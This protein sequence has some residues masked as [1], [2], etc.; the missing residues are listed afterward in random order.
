MMTD[1]ETETDKIV[2]DIL[3]NDSDDDMDITSTGVQQQ[4]QQEGG[5][6]DGEDFNASLHDAMK[7]AASFLDSDDDVDPPV[8]AAAAVASTSMNQHEADEIEEENPFGLYDYEHHTGTIMDTVATTSGDDN[9]NDD[10][11]LAVHQS[12]STL[13]A[14]QLCVHPKHAHSFAKASIFVT[15]PVVALR[16]QTCAGCQQY[17]KQGGIFSSSSNNNNR[18]ACITD[19]SVVKCMAC[20]ALAHRTCAFQS[21]LEWKEICPVNGPSIQKAV[22]GIATDQAEDE[23]V[24]TSRVEDGDEYEEAL[25][26]GSDR[27][28]RKNSSFLSHCSDQS[29]ES[30]ELEED[31]EDSATGVIASKESLNLD[32]ADPVV[33]AA[34]S[35]AQDERVKAEA[36]LASSPGGVREGKSPGA[37]RRVVTNLLFS[38]KNKKKQDIDIKKVLHNTIDEGDSDQIPTARQQQQPTNEGDEAEGGPKPE[39]GSES[40]EMVSPKSRKRRTWLR[41]D[42]DENPQESSTTGP[43]A[44]SLPSWFKRKNDTDTA[45]PATGVVEK[46]ADEP[47]ED[48]NGPLGI[49]PRLPWMSTT[50]TNAVEEDYGDAADKASRADGAGVAEDIE[51]SDEASSETKPRSGWFQRR[52]TPN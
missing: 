14:T 38:N 40:A 1:M 52:S 32:L 30:Q 23:D 7:E 39:P 6:V 29:M 16:Q 51:E 37:G 41:N 28:V 49:L 18:N 3:F 46:Q 50:A 26:D 12:L 44:D 48:K 11:L 13:T 35:A 31:G 15:A 22:E 33:A 42:G 27:G 19:P 36:D 2:S 8:A 34:V 24:S 9:N 10:E 20:G 45:D 47:D 4:Q 21:S 17:L 25:N 43:A 5:D